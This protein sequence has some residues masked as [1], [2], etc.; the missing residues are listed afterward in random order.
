MAEITKL[1]TGNITQSN[2]ENEDYDISRVS[3]T[4]LLVYVNEYIK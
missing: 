1:K 2:I 3:Y 4:S